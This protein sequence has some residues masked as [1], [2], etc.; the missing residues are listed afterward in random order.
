M[1]VGSQK[2]IKLDIR[3]IA[4][5]NRD[6]NQ[7]IKAGA[8][9]GGPLLPAQR[10]SHPFPPLRERTGDLALLVDHF[11]RKYSQKGHREVTGISSQA[12]KIAH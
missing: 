6:L 2:R 11:L 1:Q 10:H 9:P 7:A 3:I 4:S 5:S 8:F 12:L